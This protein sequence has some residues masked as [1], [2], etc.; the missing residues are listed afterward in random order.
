MNQIEM[1]NAI[2][3]IRLQFRRLTHYTVN[4]M[5]F[6]Q[7]ETVSVVQDNDAK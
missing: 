1:E 5:T 6:P 2:K 4:C 7:N 3:I